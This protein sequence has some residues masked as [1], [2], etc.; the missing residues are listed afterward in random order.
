MERDPVIRPMIFENY[1]AVLRLWQATPGVGL[2]PGD[3][4]EGLRTF[5]LRNPGLSPLALSSSGV[6]IAAAM[7]GHDGRRGT[8]YHLA[9]HPD[10]RGQG[11]GRKLVGFCLAQL[12]AQGIRRCNV[13]VFAENLTG[14][15][16][17]KH[18][19]W[20]RKDALLLL[21]RDIQR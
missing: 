18:L 6:V 2:G 17:W 4:A 10:H 9:V 20:T 11:L 1:P 14:Q 15:S 3:D 19:G 12:A 7:C 21:Q 8:I 13:L 5:L 16:F